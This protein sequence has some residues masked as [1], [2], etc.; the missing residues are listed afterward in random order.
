[1]GVVKPDL[2]KQEHRIGQAVNVF[3]AKN[4][5][6]GGDGSSAA[7]IGVDIGGSHIKCATVSAEGKILSTFEQGTPDNLEDL[8][9]A[10]CQNIE[11]LR[12]GCE[13]AQFKRDCIGI[14]VPGVVRDGI[15]VGAIDNLPF[16]KNV[17]L[18]QL[19]QE[20]LGGE[21]FV[22]NDA[23]LMALAEATF[24]AAKFNKNAIFL[25]VGTGVGGA[26][27]INGQI[28]RGTGGFAGEFGNMPVRN[29][30]SDDALGSGWTR[31]EHLA[32]TRSLIEKC[33]LLDK[34][35]AVRSCSHQDRSLDGKSIIDRYLDGDPI[36]T[37][38]IEWHFGNLMVGVS[39]LINVLDPERVIIGGG[40]STA[41]NFYVTELEKRVRANVIPELSE[42]V[43]I[44][45]A[46]L[47][48][49]AGS[50]GAALMVF[51]G[52]LTCKDGS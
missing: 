49:M 17:N 35:N 8:I 14:G 25:T 15:I 41:G 28:Y 2:G 24:G 1:M 12:S 51:E 10:I 13:T 3:D 34:K 46:G 43:E 27:L 47:G 4:L 40:I 11:R 21:F 31:L 9:L 32:S 48:N 29:V 52:A 45:T 7:A 26:L 5:P 30:G 18:R 19:L 33:E 42:K 38:A 50:I 20:A 36:A 16:L 39:T 37:E 44:V 22:E 23:N 6:A